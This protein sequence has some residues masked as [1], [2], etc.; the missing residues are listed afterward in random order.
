MNII[1]SVHIK[2]FWGNHEVN[3]SASENYNFIIGPN[4][5]GKSTVLK[6]IA[7]VLLADKAALAELEFEYIRI[8]LKEIGS[9]KTPY[10]EVSRKLDIPFAHFDYRIF[11]TSSDKPYAY[12]LSEMDGFDRNNRNSYFIRAQMV[13]KAAGKTLADHLSEMT[14]LTW[15]SVGRTSQIETI[16]GTDPID[17][18]LEEFSNRLVRYLSVVSR[19]VNALHERFQEQIFLSLLVKDDDKLSEL[20]DESKLENERIALT[21][22]FSEFRVDKKTIRKKCKHTLKN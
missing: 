19:K 16:R 18:K 4:G 7:A 2:G 8:N 17:I 12:T 21:Q 13:G 9:R 3:I 22:I 14:S 20:P 15:L 11:E 5:S 10:I 6:I 1:D